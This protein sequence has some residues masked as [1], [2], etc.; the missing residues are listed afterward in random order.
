VKRLEA[1]AGAQRR[2][3]DRMERLYKEKLVSEGMYEDSQAQTK[4][5]SEQLAGARAKLAGTQRAYGKARIL[6]PVSG[7]IESRR[8]APGDYVDGRAPLFTISSQSKLR[9][10]LPFPESLAARMRTGLKVHLT[11]P[12]APGKEVKAAIDSISPTVG[13]SRSIEAIVHVANPGGWSEGASVNAEL[14]LDEHPNALL[15]PEISVVRRPAGDVVYVVNGTIAEQRVVTTGTRQEG[16]V[17]I[18]SGLDGKETV[19]ADG[20]GFLT[21]KTPLLVKK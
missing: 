5:M 20:A 21:D 6:S 4:S 10:H 1:L 16:L 12:V 14:I 2:T 13:N 7:I 8:A 15:V 9:I 3:A 11:S 18:I 17:E 19:V